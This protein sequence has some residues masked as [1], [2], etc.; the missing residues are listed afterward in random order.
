[1]LFATSF[2]LLMRPPNLPFFFGFKESGTAESVAAAAAAGVVTVVVGVVAVV[3]V[4]VGAA[5][6]VVF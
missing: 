6:V 1:L 3:V 4:A 5:V 2:A